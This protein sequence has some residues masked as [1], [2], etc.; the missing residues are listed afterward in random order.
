MI[1]I[2]EYLFLPLSA[3][4][5]SFLKNESCRHDS[6]SAGKEKIH[7]LVFGEGNFSLA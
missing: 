4:F 7:P 6:H 1:V 2:K 5:R 3:Y